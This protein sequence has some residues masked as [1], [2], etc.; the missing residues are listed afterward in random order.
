MNSKLTWWLGGSAILLFLF[1]TFVDRRLPNSAERNLPS[2]IFTDLKTND[3]QR[4][5]VSFSTT[6]NKLKAEKEAGHWT[7]T[8][9]KY[10]AQETAISS[11][12]EVLTSLR[13]Y[14]KL[15]PHEV[16]IQGA[17]S[18]GLELPRA[19]VLVHTGTNQFTIEVGAV[20][21]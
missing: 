18:F 20:T 13:A 10:P 8:D 3:V 7:L 2:K 21:P 11:F 9:P 6:T 17:K 19:K 15:A 12:L 14:D 5:E 16:L 4:L 1:I